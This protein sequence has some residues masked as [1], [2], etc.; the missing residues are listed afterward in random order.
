MSEV[1]S[2]IV[3][4]PVLGCEM[5]NLYVTREGKLYRKK[6]YKRGIVFRELDCKDTE[7]YMKFHVRNKEINLCGKFTYL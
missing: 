7:G 3:F 1:K 2:E 5:W 4:V 6:E